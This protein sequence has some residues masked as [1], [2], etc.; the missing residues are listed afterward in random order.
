[1]RFV[2]LFGNDTN[3]RNGKKPN[4]SGNGN[5]RGKTNG[6]ASGKSAASGRPGRPVPGAGNKAPRPAGRKKRGKKAAVTIAAVIALILA[7]T[8][9]F[10]AYVNGLDTIYPNVS[11]DGI[12][13]G[14]LSLS[15]A[16]R[17]LDEAGFGNHEGQVVT[18][19]LPL[20]EVLSI[21]AEEAGVIAS[22]MDGAMA[23]Y[24]YGRDGNL[25][26]N[27]IKYVRCLLVGKNL[28]YGSSF[29]IDE[30]YVRELVKKAAN[31]VN[32]ALLGADISVDGEYVVVVKGAKS[33]TVDP[34][35]VYRL[36]EEAFRNRNFE[37]LKYVPQGEAVED[38]TIEELYETIFME[39]E[40][41]KYD[42]ETQSATEHVVG[43][44]FDK[45]LARELW[46]KA[47]KG[48]KVY[49]PLILTEPEMTTERLNGML[50]RDVLGQKTTNLTRNYARNNNITLAAKAINGLILNTGD[51][52]SFNGMVGKR[53][54][55]AGYMAA[56][57]YSG[58]RVVTEVGGGIC[59]VSSTLYY[60]TLLANLE[61][62]ERVCHNF[63]V[64]YLPIGLD[65]TVS[66]PEPDFKFVNN[67]DF[68][69]RIEAYIDLNNY[70]LTVKII[71]TNVDGSYV[72]L[73]TSVWATDD[74]YGAQSYRWVYDAD[75]NLI[76]MTEEATSKYH[77]PPKDEE[78]EPEESP[79]VSPSPSEEPSPS[80]SEEPSPSPSEEP[81]PSPSGTPS[82]QPTE[83][84]TPVPSEPVIQPTEPV[85][86]TQP[87]APT[88]SV[89]PTAS[90]TPTAEEPPENNAG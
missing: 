41:A 27:F 88:E 50:F 19:E 72:K 33:V 77:Y 31:K 15:E 23:A 76:K 85:T 38:I 6:A 59:Q 75:G 45:E 35:E 73:T 30:P 69:I 39:P 66:W 20:G 52:F 32:A 26:E 62:K 55:E 36:V 48:D 86:P 65:A 34:D 54:T 46:D 83:E 28:N 60:T 13:L 71:G 82:P 1:V 90:A 3:G 7:A 56:G 9:G 58:G 4:G 63:G 37:A 5:G 29:I 43:V 25:I 11:L 51:E 67:R 74:G 16:A 49:I 78:E 10:A 84:P 64:D 81:S 80:P 24:E 12:P 42:P 79:E 53:T 40:D 44:S 68:P 70:T 61:I 8:A 2:K 22:A 17:A 87:V 47:E 89:A 21:P 14:G 57:A 18:I